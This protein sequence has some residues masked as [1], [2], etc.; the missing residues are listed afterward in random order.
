M[1][2]LTHFFGCQTRVWRFGVRDPALKVS[3]GVATLADAGVSRGF[4]ILGCSHCCVYLNSPVAMA[5]SGSPPSWCRHSWQ[6][7]WR[8]SS[9]LS[10]ESFLG[11]PPRAHS[12]SPFNN[13]VSS[14]F[15]VLN[16]WFPFPALRHDRWKE[17]Y[18]RFCAKKCENLG[19]WITSQKIQI[20]KMNP[21]IWKPV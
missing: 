5:A 21:Q 6:F 14:W 8:V 11:A 20:T 17:Y 1:I 19:E 13:F 15:V 16:P 9:R 2:P 7:L 18:Q 10:W 3:V 12:S 4:L